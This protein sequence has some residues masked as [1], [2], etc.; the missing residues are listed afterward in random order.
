MLPSKSH[1]PF[2]VTSSWEL[3]ENLTAKSGVDKLQDGRTRYWIDEVLTVRRAWDRTGKEL[4]YEAK[5]LTAGTYQHEVDHLRGRLFVLAP[6]SKRRA[7]IVPKPSAAPE[8]DGAAS[9]DKPKPSGSRY[10]PWAEPLQRC[11][12]IDVLS[13]PGCGGRM[14]PMAMVTEPK[15][16]RRFL[17]GLG[18]TTDPPVREPA[19]G[20]PYWK[21]RVL[22]R[23]AGEVSVA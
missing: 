2:C 6:A 23:Q 22:R 10:R 8:A 18:E 11:F 7:R 14:R 4:D 16:I 1:R 9:A 17:R 19:R 15:S 3:T 12:S 20:P 21:S 5:G 13:C